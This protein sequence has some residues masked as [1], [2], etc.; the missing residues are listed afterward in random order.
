MIYARKEII[1]DCVLYQA[2]CRNILP[3]LDKMDAVLTD[4]PYGI[5]A[6]KA[7]RAAAELRKIAAAK[8]LGQRTKAGRG[9]VDYGDTNWDDERPPQDI[10]DLIGKRGDFQ[11]LIIN[12]IINN[13]FIS[14]FFIH[15]LS[16]FNYFRIDLY[17]K[18]ILVS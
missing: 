16:I 18:N 4:P 14:L 2:D 7:A 15:T 8:P 11:Q 5:G 9:W 17:K 3:H 10:F 6:D 1:G 12:L 13:V